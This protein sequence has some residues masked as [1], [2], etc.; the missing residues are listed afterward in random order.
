MLQ[1]IGVDVEHGLPITMIDMLRAEEYIRMRPEL[2][3]TLKPFRD[4]PVAAAVSF[5]IHVSAISIDESSR[6]EL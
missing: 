2:Q 4:E 6:E 5:G 3:Y 1:L